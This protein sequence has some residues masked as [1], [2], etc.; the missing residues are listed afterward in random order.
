VLDRDARQ[1]RRN[2]QPGEI[3]MTLALRI[4]A[5]ERPEIIRRQMV[6]DHDFLAVDNVII[7]VAD[8][9]GLAI[10]NIAAAMRFGEHLP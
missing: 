4:G 3:L 2:V 9:F 7:A 6:A 1:I 5:H 8:R 10:R